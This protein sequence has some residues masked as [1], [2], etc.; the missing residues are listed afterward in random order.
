[1]NEKG[2][3]W[4]FLAASKAQEDKK[5]EGTRYQVKTDPFKGWFYHT[6]DLSDVR[7]TTQLIVRVRVAKSRDRDALETVFEGVPVFDTDPNFTRRVWAKASWEAGVWAPG[8]RLLG[9]RLMRRSRPILGTS[10]ILSGTM[11]PELPISQSRHSTCWRTRSLFS[12]YLLVIDVRV[13]GHCACRRIFIS[14]ET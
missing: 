4:A 13:A 14:R 12:L 8:P 3:H 10:R 6:S 2:Y 11:I 9:R 7:A 1:M 5:G